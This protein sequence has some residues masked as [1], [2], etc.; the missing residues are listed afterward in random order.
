M[1]NVNLLEMLRA[2]WKPCMIRWL[3][4]VNFLYNNYLSL[5]ISE[6]LGAWL[7]LLNYAKLF[8]Y[9]QS[10]KLQGFINFDIWLQL[11]NSN[12][13]LSTSL[14]IWEPPYPVND[15]CFFPSFR[16]WNCEGFCLCFID[17]FQIFHISNKFSVVYFLILLDLFAR[18]A[19]LGG[20]RMHEKSKM[21][22]KTRL[23]NWNNSLTDFNCFSRL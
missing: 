5:L 19:L 14:V 2:A 9:L 10:R 6:I 1:I 20:S 23:Q 11:F 16:K 18:T 17:N 4:N 7:E 13:L 8:F 21:I 15:S 22:T 12:C 3:W